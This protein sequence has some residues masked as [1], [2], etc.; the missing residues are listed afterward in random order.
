[1]FVIGRNVEVK[2]EDGKLTIVCQIKNAPRTA[3]IAHN[4]WVLARSDGDTLIPDTDL[5]LDLILYGSRIR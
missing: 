5:S 2:V 3:N 1:M 4:R